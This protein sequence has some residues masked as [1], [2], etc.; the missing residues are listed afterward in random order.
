MS[1]GYDNSLAQ[2]ETSWGNLISHET[3]PVEKAVIPGLP[4]RAEPGIHEDFRRV[5][6]IPGRASLARNDKLNIVANH[7][8]ERLLNLVN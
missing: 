4:A 8:G 3:Q 2:R 1:E 5:F 7:V 6:W